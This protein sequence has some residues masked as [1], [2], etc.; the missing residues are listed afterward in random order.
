LTGITTVGQVKMGE[1]STKHTKQAGVGQR[2]DVQS[3]EKLTLNGLLVR[4]E[5][6]LPLLRRLGSGGRT[7]AFDVPREPTGASVRF[8]RSGTV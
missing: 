8:S 4:Q 6:V 1:L 2:G 7:S 3:R 5:V